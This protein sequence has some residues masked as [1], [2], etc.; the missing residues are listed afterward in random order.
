MP[1][2]LIYTIV[3]NGERYPLEETDNLVLVSYEFEVLSERNPEDKIHVTKFENNNC[4]IIL[5]NYMDLTTGE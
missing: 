3:V 5:S 2:N 1:E 4:Q